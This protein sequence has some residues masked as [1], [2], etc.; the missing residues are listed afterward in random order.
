[1][2]C[3][4]KQRKIGKAIFDFKSWPQNYILKSKVNHNQLQNAGNA[5]KL[6][7]HMARN[8]VHY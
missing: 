8:G 4:A 2:R 5:E 3:D 6:S 1:M 7:N